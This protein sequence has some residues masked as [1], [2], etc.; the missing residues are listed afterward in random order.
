[1][2]GEKDGSKMTPRFCLE[3]L[4]NAASMSFLTG[5]TLAKRLLAETS[6]SVVL[7]RS[8]A[9]HQYFSTQSIVSNRKE[10]IHAEWTD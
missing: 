10:K 9:T 2:T 4:R 6:E 5:M 7:L 1:M 8:R 3:H